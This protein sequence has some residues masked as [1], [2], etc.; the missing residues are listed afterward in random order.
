MSKMLN[1]TTRTKLLL[2]FALPVIL[3]LIVAGSAYRSISILQQTQSPVYKNEF[4]DALDLMNYRA[5]NSGLWASG[6]NLLYGRREEQA[7]WQQDVREHVNRINELFRRLLARNPGDSEFNQQLQGLNDL[8]HLYDKTRE[9]EIQPLIIQGKFVEAQ[10]LV[11]GI[12]E[13]RFLRMRDLS[14]KLGK[15]K[16]QE[17]ERAFTQ[18]EDL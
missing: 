13:Q 2:G 11:A 9:T 8:Q 18:A 10:S 17:A 1:L 3:L 14:S 5:D 15:E 6:L 4:A 7:V 16:L 12:Q